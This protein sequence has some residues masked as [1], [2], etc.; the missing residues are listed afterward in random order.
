M[1]DAFIH[2]A[3]ANVPPPDAWTALQHPSVWED[4]AGVE[5]ITD[6]RHDRDG[7]LIGYRF[8]VKAGPSSVRGFAKTVEAIAPSRMRMSIE[9][10]EIVGEITTLL[11]RIETERTLVT[12]SVEMRARGLLAQMFYPIVAQAVRTGLPAQVQAFAVKLGAG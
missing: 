6:A 4:I 3:V 11:E 5:Q 10:P 8:V 1:P 2:Q 9:S 7:V 12:V